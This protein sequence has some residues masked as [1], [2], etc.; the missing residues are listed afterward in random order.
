[1][2]PEIEYRL[3]HL[4]G[5]QP[6]VGDPL[7]IKQIIINLVNNANK[8]TQK[9]C[10]EVQ[11]TIKQATDEWLELLFFVRDSGIG[12][13]REKQAL[14]FESF[15]QEDSSVTRKYG[16]TGLGLTISKKMVELM[17]GKMWLESQ[18]G[19]GST[20]YFTIKLQRSVQENPK[21][22]E[23][24]FDPRVIIDQHLAIVDDNP[25]NILVIQEMLAPY[26]KHVTT[27]ETPK[28]LLDHIKQSK[29]QPQPFDLI[30][31]DIQ[32]PDI[33][34]PEVYDQIRSQGGRM[35]IIAASSEIIL[36]TQ[37]QNKFEGFIYKPIIRE[38]L[39]TTISRIFRTELEKT[40]HSTTS[41]E[42]SYCQMKL[43]VA[44]DNRLNQMLIKKIISDL[45]P[46]GLDIVDNGS[47]AL[48]QVA[49]KEYDLVLMDINMPIM[50][51]L[52]ATSEIRKIRPELPI[53]ALT[54]NTMSG[55]RER[56]LAAGMNGFIGKPIQLHEFKE[57]LDRHI[58]RQHE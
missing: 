39:L 35:P 5:L 13:A 33:S 27:F 42:N 58:R 21:A 44:E 20:F 41:D 18:P 29:N 17:G 9:G 55:D 54:A 15:V 40:E 12:I 48:E 4:Q 30:I 38:E 49:I 51:G 22:E 47:K 19:K 25:L 36:N 23:I 6:V 3:P 14:I 28:Q 43:L 16:G 46:A 32:M 52:S 26:T 45:K 1:M 53:Y 24:E 50:D 11:T 56:C 2:K 57:V 34:G 7:K 8:F 37:M 31:T 10:I